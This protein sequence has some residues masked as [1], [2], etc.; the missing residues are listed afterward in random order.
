MQCL[1]EESEE[2]QNIN[3]PSC[4]HGGGTGG[5]ISIQKTELKKKL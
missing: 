2:Q 5:I 3:Y 1:K 4:G